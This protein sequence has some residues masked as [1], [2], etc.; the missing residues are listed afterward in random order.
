MKKQQLSDI[1]EIRHGMKLICLEAV[2]D[3]SFTVTLDTEFCINTEDVWIV[4]CPICKEWHRLEY[5]H[6][7]DDG[8]IRLRG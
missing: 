3:K 4:Y 5:M 1:D 6:Y 2:P 7:E 8:L